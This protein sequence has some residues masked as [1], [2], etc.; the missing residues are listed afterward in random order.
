MSS[1]PFPPGPGSS[2]APPGWLPPVPGWPAGGPEAPLT[3]AAVPAFRAPVTSSPEP[4]LATCETAGPRIAA[5]LLD[6]GLATM[7]T[8]GVLRLVD[9][10]P[11]RLTALLLVLTFAGW[12]V[13]RVAGPMIAGES[14]GKR[15]LNLQTVDASGIPVPT[16]TR[17][18][19]ELV[20]WL[21]Y[22]VP[23]VALIDAF[24]VERGEHRSMRDRM[25]GTSVVHASQGPA[26]GG[27]VTAVL[28]L[29]VLALCVA[30]AGVRHE[31]SG[32]QLERGFVTGCVRGGLGNA[33]CRCIFDQLSTGLPRERIVQAD[34]DVRLGRSMPPDVQVALR[35]AAQGCVRYLGGGR[36]LPASP[37]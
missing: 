19:R 11:E 25:A 32:G 7:L 12:A 16:G 37:A 3:P 5:Y 30:W 1:G 4:G 23:F 35:S 22:W 31:T 28:V 8:F 14:P 24:V 29:G 33:E 27:R 34:R 10:S 26:S 21:I 17:A 20:I 13:V 2:S 6:I 18:L 15:M 36:A 9:A